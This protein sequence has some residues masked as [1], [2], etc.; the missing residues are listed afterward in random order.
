MTS[1]AILIPTLKRPY[2]LAPLVENIHKTTTIPH[3]IYFMTGDIESQQILDELNET[4]FVDHGDTWPN[5]INALF[6]KTMEPYVFLCSDYSW[7][8]PGWDSIAMERMEDIDGIVVVND[9]HNPNGTLALVSRNYIDTMSGCIDTP[10]VVIYPGYKHNYSDGELFCTARIRG[11]WA[12]CTD[13]IVEHLHPHAGKAP[14]DEVY[15]M[16][17]AWNDGD[18][19]TFASRTHLWDDIHP[20]Q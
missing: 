14:H 17:D 6:H 8:H 1:I 18:A 2:R 13:S 12:Q 3:K 20:S 10:N 5:R 16:G 9:L 19:A 7:F 11:K 15:A 4:C